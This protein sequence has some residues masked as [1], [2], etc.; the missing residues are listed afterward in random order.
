MNFFSTIKH[1]LG[2]VWNA[3]AKGAKAV[4]N[5]EP[6]I[7]SVAETAAGI[8]E[9]FDPALTPVLN[10]AFT[11]LGALHGAATS[12]AQ[13]QATITTQA[14]P[15]G[16]NLVNVQVDAK[17]LAEIEALYEQYKGDFDQIKQAIESAKSVKP[18]ESAATSNQA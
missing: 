6:K 8:A 15:T 5:D 11:A 1:D 18:A 9:G 12:T 17:I 3:V 13:T 10:A 2:K 4:E 14:G 16:S 7:A